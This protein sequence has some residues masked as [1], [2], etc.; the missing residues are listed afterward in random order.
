MAAGPGSIS[1]SREPGESEFRSAQEGSEQR[2]VCPQQPRM[3]LRAVILTL[4]LVTVS[5]Y[6]SDISGEL[7]AN[8]AWDYLSQ[9]STNG[10]DEAQQITELT[11]QLRNLFQYHYL[12]LMYNKPYT[13][14]VKELV[15][16][17]INLYQGLTKDS[18]KS[19]E[20]TRKELQELRAKMLPH[21]QEVSQKIE[22]IV[23]RLPETVFEYSK[24]EDNNIKTQ[25]WMIAG[26][27]SGIRQRLETALHDKAGDP[28]ALLASEFDLLQKQNINDLFEVLGYLMGYE[29][30]LKK[31]IDKQV[32]AL[33]RSLAPLAQDQQEKLKHQL[34]GLSFQMK[35]AADPLLAKVPPGQEELCYHLRNLT[36]DAREKVKGNREELL[37]AL[38]ELGRRLDQQIQD[39]G[40]SLPLSEELFQKAIE[41]LLREFGRKLGPNAG[42]GDDHLIFL[43]K[44]LKDKVKTF[45]NNIL[46]EV[47]EKRMALR[48]QEGNQTLGEQNPAPSEPSPTPSGPNPAICNQPPPLQNRFPFS[49]HN[50]EA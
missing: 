23:R 9:P 2:E 7:V 46:K 18:E 41:Q 27:I 44:E 28:Q 32:Q 19:K 11:Q 15:P 21:A 31:E 14:D 42:D 5:G 37:E 8:V 47:H 49:V 10:K 12:A 38:A 39:S 22:D 13:Y 40:R 16:F 33:G 43:E 45:F 20:E 25:K 35:K 4:A 26:R 3:V 17:A 24:I 29:Y 34:D 50:Q 30:E 36:E 6:N 48:S 1:S